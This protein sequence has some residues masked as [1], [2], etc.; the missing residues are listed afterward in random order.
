MVCCGVVCCAERAAQWQAI[1]YVSAAQR[2]TRVCRCPLAPPSP[3]LVAPPH[4]LVLLCPARPSCPPTSDRLAVCPMA[5]LACV[6][7]RETGHG[8]VA[9]LSCARA[10]TD[11]VRPGGV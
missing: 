3:L 8:V 4:L 5:F 10:V 7:Y 6:R 9:R 11:T 1:W 2:R